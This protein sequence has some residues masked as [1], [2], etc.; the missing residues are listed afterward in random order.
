LTGAVPRVGGFHL[1]GV[2]PLGLPFL[3]SSPYSCDMTEGQVV[4]VRQFRKE[5][6]EQTENLR[7]NVLLPERG[8]IQFCR[9]CG[10][11]VS[12][13]LDGDPGDFF[14]HGWL[15]ADG[16][17]H[18]GG[19]LF[20]PFRIYP[21][22]RILQLEIAGGTSSTPAARAFNEETI[23]RKS[24]AWNTITDLADVL[25]PIYWPRI[26]GTLTF[27]GDE[28]SHRTRLDS[29]RAKT[30]PFVQ[31]LDAKEWATVHESLRQEASR[32][33]GNSEIYVLLRLSTWKARSKMTGRICGA[34][35]LRHMA[36]VIRRAFEEAHRVQW[37][38][39]D[40]AFG[41][42]RPNG[43]QRA[44]GSERP[45]DDEFHSR[46][47][48]AYRFG[49]FTGSAVRW[50]MEGDTEFY[51]VDQILPQWHKV[52]IELLNL[53]GSIAE[54]KA[55]AAV[56]LADMLAQDRLLRRFSIISFDMDVKA[57]EKAIRQLVNAN[58]IVGSIAANRPDFEFANFS[59]AELA[60][61]AARIDEAHGF[62]GAPL[63]GADWT[64]IKTAGDFERRYAQLSERKAGSL[65]GEEWGRALAT[66][67]TENLRR[68]DGADRPLWNE[69][70]A[71]VHCWNSNYDYEVNHYRLDPTT[72]S[73]VAR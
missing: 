44:F 33:D 50:Y 12:G 63:R 72:F 17:N 7:Q 20:H 8:F 57:N 54:S 16:I 48:I 60:E 1:C 49:L 35:W 40:R 18:D 51:A 58:Q 64:A 34:L 53:K 27:T 2:V 69:I 23:A 6:V 3:P 4:A 28:Q 47:Y 41:H 22:Y 21:L 19:P 10:I 38:E 55:N 70:S 46:P 32:L 15:E 25:E 71:A 73:R 43:R 9:R 62:S 11:P 68:P 65:K 13:L 67:A 42:W 30:V 37:L 26:R 59:A 39:E 5:V 14:K 45:Y 52:G 31:V 29:Y 36:E 66:Y 56:R 61:V 24:A